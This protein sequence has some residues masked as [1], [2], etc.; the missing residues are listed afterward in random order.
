MNMETLGAPQYVTRTTTLVANMI[1]S[2]TFEAALCRGTPI[3]RANYTERLRIGASSIGLDRMRNG[4]VIPL[5]DSLREDSISRSLA[6]L[7]DVNIKD[8]ALVGKIQC[9]ETSEGRKAATLVATGKCDIAIAYGVNEVEVYDCDNRRV[10]PNDTERANE[11][12]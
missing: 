7:V 2:R 3:E 9:H 11:E 1:D 12:G 10:D 6:K 4:C 5:L 8:G